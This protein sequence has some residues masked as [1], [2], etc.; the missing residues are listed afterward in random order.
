MKDQQKIKSAI[1]LYYDE[2]LRNSIE[3]AY[4]CKQALEQACIVAITDE[5]GIIKEV[6]DNF[7]IISKYNREELIGQDYRIINSGHHPSSFI[8]ELWQTIKTEKYGKARY[9]TGQ[10]TTFFTG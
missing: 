4:D 10:R 2:K 6:N 8:K 9:V 1:S 3:E 5:K 7:C